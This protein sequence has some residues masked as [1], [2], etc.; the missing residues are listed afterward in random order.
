MKRLE[1]VG[2]IVF[3]VLL[4]FHTAVKAEIAQ[5][6]YADSTGWCLSKAFPAED[7]IT[8]KGFVALRLYD[9]LSDGDK[10]KV[11]NTGAIPELMLYMYKEGAPFFYGFTLRIPDSTITCWSPSSEI[12]LTYTCSKDKGFWGTL[13]HRKVGVDTIQIASSECFFSTLKQERPDRLIFL[14]ALKSD[15]VVPNLAVDLYSKQVPLVFAKFPFQKLP[16][17]LLCC[18]VANVRSVVKG[19]KR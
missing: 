4:L 14:M 3:V 19:G 2:V 17:E 1:I 18:K 15:F 16:D 9:G 10:V 13:L 8:T 5:P 12:V 7:I 6:L 11:E